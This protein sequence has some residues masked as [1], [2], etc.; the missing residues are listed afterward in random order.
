M[1]HINKNVASGIVYLWDEWSDKMRA[2]L[3]QTPPTNLR[4][5]GMWGDFSCFEPFADQVETLIRDYQD[6][7]KGLMIR[8][9]LRGN[10]LIR[11]FHQEEKPDATLYRPHPKSPTIPRS[12]RLHR[13]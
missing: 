2:V 11:T 1:S 8:F 4:L 7:Y 12:H 13:G 9:C 3:E 10:Y 6:L 5:D